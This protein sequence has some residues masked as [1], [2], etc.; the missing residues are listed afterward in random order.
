MP[1]SRSFYFIRHGQ[2]DWNLEGRMQ[3]RTDIP[4]NETEREQARAAILY[5]KN[6]NIDL[7][8]SS[9]LKR[10]FETAEI[11]GQA[12][13]LKVETHQDLQERHFGSNEG[14]LTSE[15]KAEYESNPNMEV[16]LGVTGFPHA[17]DSETLENLIGEYIHSDNAVPYHFQKHDDGSWDI[18]KVTL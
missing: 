8:V 13:N 5:S 3:G 9:P 18:E 1:I 11:I 16:Q 7:I 14:R 10:A 6:L 4:L 17:K 12:L 15:I 2:T